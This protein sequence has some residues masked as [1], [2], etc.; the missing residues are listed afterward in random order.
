[1]LSRLDRFMLAVLALTASGSALADFQVPEPG[2]LGLVGI[3]LVA[4]IAVRIARRRK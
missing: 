3:G 1:M 4:V 2:A